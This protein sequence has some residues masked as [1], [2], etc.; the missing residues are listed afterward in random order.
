MTNRHTNFTKW[1]NDRLDTYS[2][3]CTSSHLAHRNPRVFQKQFN[4]TEFDS[5][6]I[7]RSNQ[8]LSNLVNF[9]M[10]N[11]AYSLCVYSIVY[12]RI[13]VMLFMLEC[14]QTSP[15]SKLN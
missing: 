1:I 6:L 13:T 15:Q 2:G 3:V 5:L 12:T 14:L 4:S 9:Y 10:Q 11:S 8:P 7:C